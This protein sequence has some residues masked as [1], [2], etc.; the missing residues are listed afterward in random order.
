MPFTRPQISS[1]DQ[2]NL[3]AEDKKTTETIQHARLI[4][5]QFRS[6]SDIDIKTAEA[7]AKMVNAGKI[8]LGLLAYLTSPKLRAESVIVSEKPSKAKGDRD[9]SPERP[10]AAVMKQPKPEPSSTEVESLSLESSSTENGTGA[11]M[12]VANRNLGENSTPNDTS[13]VEK[14]L[15]GEP[16]AVIGPLKEGKKSKKNGQS[17]KKALIERSKNENIFTVSAY[18]TQR[19]PRQKSVKKKGIIPDTLQKGRRVVGDGDLGQVPPSGP[20][21]RAASDSESFEEDV[22]NPCEIPEGMSQKSS[23]PRSLISEECL[24]SEDHVAEEVL[25]SEL[26]AA[27]TP[28]SL[29]DDTLVED[30]TTVADKSIAFSPTVKWIRQ[31]GGGAQGLLWAYSIS[32]DVDK[33]LD[34]ARIWLWRKPKTYFCNKPLLRTEKDGYPV[35]AP[36]MVSHKRTAGDEPII[37]Y[38]GDTVHIV[39]REQ[40]WEDVR[41]HES[42]PDLLVPAKLSDYQACEA[43]GYRVWRHDRDLLP[44]RKLGCDAMVSDYQHSTVICL[45]CGPKSNV[46]YCSL[47]H[48]MEDFREHWKECGTW[49]VLLRRVIDHSTAPRKF[50]RMCPAIKQKH[51]CR[52][53]AMHRQL[54]GSTLTNGHYTVFDSDSTYFMT[55]YWPKHDARWPEM[56]RRIERLLNLAF[57]DSW[58]HHILG[59]LYRL[60]RELLRSQGKW[61]AKTERSLKSQFE[62]E[63]SHYKVNPHWHNGDDPCECEWSGK[64]LPRWDHLATCCQF[65]RTAEEDWGPVRRQN[66]VAAIVEDYEERFWILRAWRQQHETQ[67]NWRRRAAGY[68][69]SDVIVGEGCY[70]LGPGW[71]GWGGEMDNICEDRRNEGKNSVWSV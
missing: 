34:D 29:S 16:T 9:E 14:I 5:D 32:P 26:I 37:E 50:A 2:S 64:I 39:P 28:C 17:R 60:L 1:D 40:C 67:H 69:F 8:S 66:C 25:N 65:A 7:T 12:I 35:L 6:L 54:L 46:R 52:T 56:D 58:N 41:S 22:P 62:S 10:S 36:V 68:G 57:L 21:S 4:N 19:P 38:D 20:P 23:Y 44:C 47:Q 59:Y 70:E 13:I 71:T 53:A 11:L 45:G 43:A 30:L 27:K 55:L 18:P 31:Y 61:T 63:F 51:G 42:H 24:M 33:S 15:I 49:S 48:Q 3:Y